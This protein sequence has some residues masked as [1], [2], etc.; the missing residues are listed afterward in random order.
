VLCVSL[1]WAARF[2]FLSLDEQDRAEQFGG[3]LIDCAYEHSLRPFYAAGPCVRGTPAARRGR[4]AQ[5]SPRYMMR[6]LKA[7]PPYGSDESKCC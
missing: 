4:R 6:L 1:A 2:V 3:E 7:T 5:Y